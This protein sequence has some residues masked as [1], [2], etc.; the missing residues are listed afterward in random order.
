MSTNSKDYSE[1]CQNEEREIEL[2]KKELEKQNKKNKLKEK[3]SNILM[4]ICGMI[5][6]VGSIIGI[7]KLGINITLIGGII[8]GLLAIGFGILKL[9]EII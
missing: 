9:K 5:F 4:C 8:F 7:I 1:Y 3:I 2:K 6:F